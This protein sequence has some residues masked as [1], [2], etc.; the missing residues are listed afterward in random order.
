MPDPAPD[1][2]APASRQ[3]GRMAALDAVPRDWDMPLPKSIL[4][5]FDGTL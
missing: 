1:A 3:L 4:D 5:Q 2:T